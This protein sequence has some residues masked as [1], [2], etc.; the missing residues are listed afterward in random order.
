M[1]RLE[2]GPRLVRGRA[3]P[4]GTVASAAAL[5]CLLAAAPAGAAITLRSD[6]GAKL[7]SFSSL[8]CKQTKNKGFTGT[9]R[10]GAWKLT[11]RIQ[12]FKK[13]GF[14]PLLYG[15]SPAR[16]FASDGSTTY[17]NTVEAENDPLPAK[18]GGNLGFPG[19]RDKIGISFGTAFVAGDP[20]RYGSL[21]GLATCTY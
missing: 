14:F 8:T 3:K 19:G 5:A 21:F 20:S 15:S 4:R 12:P 9:D 7:A 6:S 11:V 2:R 17:S 16:F 18:K 10:S 13:F 1:T